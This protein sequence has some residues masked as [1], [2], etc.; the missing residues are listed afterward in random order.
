M[1][2]NIIV[3]VDELWL[4]GKNRSLYFKS[5]IKH[6]RE[7]LWHYHGRDFSCEQE[8]HRILVTTKSFFKDE[9]YKAIRR[10]PGVHSFF[11]AKVLPVKFEEIYPAVKEML[12]SQKTLPKSFKVKTIRS[13][14]NFSKNSLE[15]SRSIGGMILGD[16]PNLKVQMKDAELVVQIN[17]TSDN[18][19]VSVNKYF[20]MGGQPYG[21][22]GHLITL[23]SGG[24]DSPVA[25]YLMAKR[26]CSQ[27]FTFFY[28][29][30]FVSEDVKEK[31]LDLASFLGR[32]QRETQLYIIPFG[33]IQKKI[34][35]NCR[36]EYRTLLFRKYMVECAGL[37]AEKLN[38]EAL[39]TGD[40]LA[41][42][43]SQTM[44]NISLIDS[45]SKLSIFRPLLGFNKS[46]TISLAND[47]GTYKISERPHDDACSL[48][49]PKHPIIKPD[50]KYWE[51]Y[52][53]GFNY[54]NE[55][56]ECLSNAEVF[57]ISICGEVENIK[58]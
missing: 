46:E 13:F 7:T 18:I 5:L 41:Q 12:E 29:Y 26:G 58:G 34:A 16:F 10:V 1:S 50:K 40:S 49:A 57:N 20:G 47:I 23:L 33:E 24:F 43:S 54:I 17:I 42:V 45:T 56:N 39:C 14:K 19:F 25:S 2:E 48:F 32:F 4:R 37:L 11:L 51:D 30:P 31:I 38:A 8:G 6:V 21:T 44:G 27:T 53:K 28:S 15:V 35:K 36:E 22:T 52:D 9:T 55:L 3:N